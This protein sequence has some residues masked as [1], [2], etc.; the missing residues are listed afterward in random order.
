MCRTEKLRQYLSAGAKEDHGKQESDACEGHTDADGNHD[1]PEMT[2]STQN[3]QNENT[4]DFAT[5][6]APCLHGWLLRMYFQSLVLVAAG[7]SVREVGSGSFPGN[8]YA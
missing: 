3:R 2:Q 6:V 4:K 8:G 7:G 1:V 5:V